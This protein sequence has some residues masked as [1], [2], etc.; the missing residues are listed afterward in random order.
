MYDEFI[1]MYD[2]KID[3]NTGR[4]S[5]TYTCTRATRATV[6]ILRPMKDIP[7]PVSIHVEIDVLG[8]GVFYNRGLEEN[9]QNI[10][11]RVMLQYRQ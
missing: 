9:K 1:Y 3:R 2:D 5:I 6:N 11:I 4:Q 8:G 7:P 10:P